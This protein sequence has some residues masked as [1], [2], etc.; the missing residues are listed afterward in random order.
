MLASIEEDN[1][2][3]EL[4]EKIRRDVV[5]HLD[6]QAI[7]EYLP[8]EKGDLEETASNTKALEH[9]IDFPPQTDLSFA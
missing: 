9:L 4:F 5:I 6:T 1:L 7:K 2:L 3:Y 8:I